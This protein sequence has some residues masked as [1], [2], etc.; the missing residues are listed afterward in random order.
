MT[1]PLRIVTHDVKG[2]VIRTE[3]N[4]APCKKVRLDEEIGSIAMQDLI[5]A[6]REELVAK[7]N[8]DSED[9]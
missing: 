7:A 5:K 3:D 1:K 2:A 9:N 8:S 4:P 6:K